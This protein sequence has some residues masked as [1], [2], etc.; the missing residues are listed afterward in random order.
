MGMSAA[1]LT[2]CALEQYEP[3]PLDQGAV[4]VSQATATLDDRA[5]GDLLTRLGAAR[6]WPLPQWSPAQ[7]GLLAVARSRQVAAARAA[8]AGAVAERALAAQWPNPLTTL[9]LEH[10]ADTDQ[11]H[12]SHWSV[13]P[14]FAFTWSPSSRRRIA[15]ALADVG[16][17]SARAQVAEAAWSARTTTV[18]AALDV[19]EQH[20]LMRLFERSTAARA[21]VIAAARAEVAAG[22]ADSFEWQTLQLEANAARMNQFDLLTATTAAEVALAS[23]LNLPLRA[24]EGM[25]IAMP[26]ALAAPSYGELQQ[27]MLSTHPQVLLALAAYAR[28]EHELALAIAAQYPDIHL[29]PGYFFDQGANVWSLLGGIVVPVFASHKVAIKAA[30]AARDTAREQFYAV[31]STSIATLQSAFANWQVSATALTSARTL[32]AEIARGQTELAAKQAAGVVGQLLVARAELQLREM[33]VRVAV[34]AARLRR[35]GCAL[36]HAARSVASNTA[37]ADYLRELTAAATD[38]SAAVAAP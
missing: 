32:A 5:H 16:T 29:S 35:N 21:A 18:A 33:D 11:G 36:E 31:Q 2:A 22:V 7:L 6:Q 15:L 17:E 30:T 8:I 10:H 3:A 13:G 20:E 27:R 34:A 1:L 14:S 25:A 38:A 28:S 4:A 26:S 9:M 24:I 12:T 19:L 23:A 37:F